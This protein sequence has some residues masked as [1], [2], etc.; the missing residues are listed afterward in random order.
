VFIPAFEL[1]QEKVGDL[2]TRIERFRP[3]LIDGYAESLKYLAHA[4]RESSLGHSPVA[5]MTSAQILD[6]KTR[7][8]IEEKLRTKV[9]DKYGS[10]EF[11]GVAYECAA[12]NGHHVQWESYIVELLVGSRPAKPGEFGEVVVTDLNNYSVPLVRYRVGDVAQALSPSVCPCGRAS[13]RIGE[14]VGRTQALVLVSD[15]VWLPG[16][17]FAHFFKEYDAILQNFQ[18]VQE[19]AE[20]FTLKAVKGLHWSPEA[21]D[22]MLESLREFTGR[23]TVIRV[24]FVNS[25]PLGRT[26]KRTPV[27]SSLALDYQSI[28]PGA[29]KAKLPLG[30]K[31]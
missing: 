8:E 4:L 9:F 10:R 28:L 19:N 27:V 22:K 15:G 7:S 18:V 30:A 1:N 12:H 6:D 3:T 13:L 21:F 23:E 16:T 17:F 25:I 20:S 14:I 26:G 31:R 29:V 5:V 2:L 11:S 24:D